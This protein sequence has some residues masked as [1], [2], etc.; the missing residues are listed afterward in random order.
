MRI[1]IAI[2]S[3]LLSTVCAFSQAQQVIPCVGSSA[4]C[5]P[6]TAAAPLPTTGNTDIPTYSGSV[7]GIANTGTGDVYCIQGSATKIVKVKGVRVSAV[8]TA[9][10]TIPAV[11]IRR[12]TL[13]SGGTSAAVT[14]VPSDSLNAAGTAVVKSYSVSP[15]P[16]T[17]V[18]QIRTEKLAIGTQ[19]SAN[20]SDTALF[21]FTVYWNQ[22]QVLRGV[23]ESLCVSLPVAAGAGASLDID[24]E[25]TEE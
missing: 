21:Q 1:L 25:H 3:L 17:A 7:T 19:G 13:D 23:N 15:T 8:A 4:A 14:L 12:S 10:I 6:V 2:F 11:L 24:H 9:A 16:G 20:S 18:G 5:A 22:P